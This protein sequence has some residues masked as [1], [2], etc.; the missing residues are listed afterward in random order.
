MWKNLG[1]FLALWVLS[2]GGLE[3]SLVTTT[4][5]I[6]QFSSLPVN[7][8]PANNCYQSTGGTTSSSAAC[9]AQAG[10][11]LPGTTSVVILDNVAT[12]N[13]D[14]GHL[15]VQTTSQYGSVDDRLTIPQ[16]SNS[17][18]SVSTFSDTFTIDDA[19]LNGTP[20]TITFV[21]AVEGR[22]TANG[23]A[24]GTDPIDVRAAA[25]LDVSAA[26]STPQQIRLLGS[27]IIV[28]QPVSFV[29]GAPFAFSASLIGTSTILG[30]PPGF[31][32]SDV[33][34]LHT[35]NFGGMEVFDASFNPV[36]DFTFSAESGTQYQTEPV[37]EPA[38]LPLVATAIA[39]LL[40]LGMRRER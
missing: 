2:T 23:L 19:A 40:F 34:F 32:Y 17:A 35:A 5:V 4:E 15:G 3:A 7:N 33:S 25:R 12:A 30:G 27:A 22:L 13:A 24:L 11:P 10:F 16:T 18:L 29:F 37:P 36:T 38:T 39:G 21:F 26:G 8:W 9:T 1:F 28:S 14:Y 20:G 31:G 6:G